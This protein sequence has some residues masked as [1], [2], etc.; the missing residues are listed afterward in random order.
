MCSSDLRNKK[1]SRGVQ[2]AP[3][4]VVD[5]V[6]GKSEDMIINIDED[7]ILPQRD[8]NRYEL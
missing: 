4:K 8:E 2:K 7:A 5:S 6:E 1:K 3:K